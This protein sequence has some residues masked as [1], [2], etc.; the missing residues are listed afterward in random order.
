M[1]PSEYFKKLDLGALD[2]MTAQFI[3]E[4]IYTFKNVDLLEGTKEFEIL[5]NKIESDFPLALGI[6][7]KVE[8]APPAKKKVEPV[9]V[10][11]KKGKVKVSVS[12]KKKKIEELTNLISET[13]E[14]I[15]LS[16]M[17]LT[18]N[19]NDIETRICWS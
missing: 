10:E 9:K 14:M 3:R 19:P 11:P 7:P 8:V 12:E 17:T 13:N 2:S 15:E 4:K 16:E 6:Q 1:K 5:Q 18:V